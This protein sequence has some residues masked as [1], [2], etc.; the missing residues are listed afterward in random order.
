[1]AS[2]KVLAS[3]FGVQPAP[4][5]VASVG[6]A[7]LQP[8][9]GHLVLPADNSALQVY[10]VLRDVQVAKLQV[11][12]ERSGCA[13]RQDRQTGASVRARASQAGRQAGSCTCRAAVHWVD[14]LADAFAE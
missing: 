12:L 6:N 8:R 14:G 9:S 2:M 13:T 4:E 11:G 10:D 5:G 1:M 7:V 3:V